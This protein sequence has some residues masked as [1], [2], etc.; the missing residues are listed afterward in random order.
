MQEEW[1]KKML[2][3]VVQPERRQLLPLP[4]YLLIN[5]RMVGVMRGNGPVRVGL[6][7]GEYDVTVRSVYKW[8]ESTVHVRM[9]SGK[10]VCLTFGD[11]ER[12]WN[13]VFNLDLLLWLAKRVLDLGEP[14]NMVYEILSNG[15]FL[16]WLLRLV[17]VRKHYFRLHATELDS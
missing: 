3:L 4:H 7:E 17:M 8:I 14:W 5:G 15:F 13:W 9:A 11:R 1:D 10:R 6:P 16:V 12:L 2:E